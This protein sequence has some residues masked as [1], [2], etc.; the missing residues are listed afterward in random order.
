[1]KRISSRIIHFS[2]L[3]WLISGLSCFLPEHIASFPLLAAGRLLFIFTIPGLSL[4]SI[5]LRSDCRFRIDYISLA[6]ISITLSVMFNM[7]ITFLSACAGI[8]SPPL[9]WIL[10]TVLLAAGLWRYRK[11]CVLT[12]CQPDKSMWLLVALLLCA[13]VLY[14]R[15]VTQIIGGRDPGVYFS[16]GINIA[17]TGGL[18]EKN[19]WLSIFPKDK[20]M[21]YFAY[22]YEVDTSAP[23]FLPGFY[24]TDYTRGEITPQFYHL[25]STIFTLLYPS[26]GISGALYG[27]P[28]L[29]LLALAMLFVFLK[30]HT[31]STVMAISA[32]LFLMISAQQVWYARYPNSEIMVQLCFFS[33]L[34]LLTFASDDQPGFWRL[35]GWVLGMAF[36]ARIDSFLIVPALVATGLI[37]LLNI[38]NLSKNIGLFTLTALLLFVLS[39]LYGYLFSHP[40]YMSRLGGLL[41]EHR[42][43]IAVLLVAT[44]LLVFVVYLLNN[45]TWIRR[46]PDLIRIICAGGIIALIVTGSLKNWK[47]LTW[48]TWYLSTPLVITASLGCILYSCKSKKDTVRDQVIT[49]IILATLFSWLAVYLPNPRIRP[50]H[51][52]AIRRF[53]AI[54]LPLLIVFSAYFVYIFICR[55]S[56]F[57]RTAGVVLLVVHLLMIG[58][59]T[60]PT[61]GFDEC[62]EIVSGLESASKHIAP[63][64][65]LFVFDATI[66]LYGTPLY[67]TDILDHR[68]L[69]PVGQPKHLFRKFSHFEQLITPILESGEQVY[70]L[71]YKPQ[72]FPFRSYTARPVARIPIQISLVHKSPEG[73]PQETRPIFGIDRNYLYI[74]KIE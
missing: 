45:R 11:I 50:D 51:F 39:Q 33:A 72:T 40:Y 15:P 44:M 42:V 73:L 41:I 65:T 7:S 6:I 48:F 52:W 2:V 26:A 23:M 14:A 20:Y 27:T 10:H 4:L 68:R 28:F 13:A 56:L 47:P 70:A 17:K 19:H 16:T 49:V 71:S 9:L 12:V 37:C 36:F 24:I 1:M 63:N 25:Y 32:T 66:G 22:L 29:A 58:S 8:Y 18:I 5:C 55:N 64:S 57:L 67:F 21:R 34:A 69:I 30:R 43:S 31:G 59:I 38:G 61:I 60:W 35:A 62:E 54:V 46:L 3:L 53:S 74:W